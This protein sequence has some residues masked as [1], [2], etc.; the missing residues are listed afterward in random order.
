MCTHFGIRSAA[1][2]PIRTMV[3]GPE[4]SK[5]KIPHKTKQVV[6]RKQ[7]MSQFIENNIWGRKKPILCVLEVIICRNMCFFHNFYQEI[8]FA[9]NSVLRFP[10]KLTIWCLSLI[11]ITSKDYSKFLW[12]VFSWHTNVYM[13][14]GPK[15]LK[16]H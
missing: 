10:W 5:I 4:E 1:L 11:D 12:F 15:Y 14:F 2:R 3:R 7:H 13:N 9:K 16:K 6:L 8:F